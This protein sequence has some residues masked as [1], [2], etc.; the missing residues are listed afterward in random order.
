MTTATSTQVSQVESLSNPVFQA[1]KI[2]Q[3]GFTVAPILFGLDK[4]LNLM[5]NWTQYL[6]PLF[7]NVVPAGPFMLIVGV[8][9]IVAA[10][11]HQ[12]T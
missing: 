2:L 9:E 8:V 4:F 10:C 6:A 1:F 11:R 5:V 3:I 7:A 12:A